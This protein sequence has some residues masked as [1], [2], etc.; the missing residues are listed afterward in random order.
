[1]TASAVVEQKNTMLDAALAYLANEWSVFP[2]CTPIVGRADRCI[3]G[4]HGQSKCKNPGKEPLVKWGRYQDQLATREE[5]SQWW[6]RWPAANIGMATGE[7]SDVVVVDLDGELAVAE[8]TRRGYDPGPWVRTGRVGGK[9]L[10]CRYRPDAPTIFAK[11]SGIDFRGQGGYA[12]LPPSLHYTGVRYGWG[13]TVRRGE[14]LPDLPRW[15]D[16]LAQTNSSGG[17]RK[18][19]EF[20]KLLVDGLSEGQRDQELFRAAAKLRGADVP[21][22]FALKLIEWAAQTCQPPF[23]PEQARAKVDSAY[24]R[25]T[26]NGTVAPTSI[27]VIG[28]LDLA[29]ARFDQVRWA[30][31]GILPSGL[32][33]LAGRPKLGKSWL[34]LGWVLDIA[35]GTPVLRNL[36]IQQGETLYLALEDSQRRM[37]ERQARLIGDRLSSNAFQIATSWPR[38]GEGGI[39]ALEDWLD[40]HVV[41]LVVIDTFKRFRPKEQKVQRLYD[42]DYDAIAPLAELAARR[43]VA[44]VLV[45]HTN[46][47]DPSDPIDLMSGTLG[48]SGAADGVLVLKRERGQADA[49]LFVTG[50]DVEEQDLALKWERDD[51]FGWALLGQASDFRRSKERQE[52]LD[53]VKTMPGMTPTEIANATQRKLGTVKYL[54]FV[55]VRDEEIRNRDGHYYLLDTTPNPPNPPS[56]LTSAQPLTVVRADRADSTDS[57]VRE[58]RGHGQNHCRVC[59]KRLFPDEQEVCERCQ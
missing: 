28:G 48:L 39:E 38:M 12:V 54:L 9:H 49:S 33:I 10:Y 5:V 52:I 3:Q 23:D 13:E 18:Q 58:D 7:L 1:V 46:K 44:V 16:E 34:V 59:R 8:A 55:M 35:L 57:T 2:V 29:R 37:Q 20:E 36:P 11:T 22:D 45:F 21:Y 27:Q 30:I 4:H 43:N 47:L 51:P 15:I 32:T 25:Y 6:S 31:P 14:P 26:P 50:R 56:P 17:T 40:N 42:L 53:V 41:R 24:G 19:V